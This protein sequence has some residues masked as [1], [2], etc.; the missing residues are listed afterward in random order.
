MRRLGLDVG[1]TDIKL[2]L[3]EDDRIVATDAT[4]TRSEDGGPAAV[5][6][7]LIDLGRSAGAVDSVGVSVPG[8]FDGDGRG[9]L[10]PNL[11]G[12]WAR[13]P[14]R[15][16]ASEGFGSPVALLNDGHAFTLAE[17]RVGA[18][19]GS[20]DVLCVVC[21]TG[22][23]GGLVLGGRL[24][25]GIEDRAGEI[26]HHTVERDGEPC[27]CGNHGCLETIAGARAIARAAGRESFVVKLEVAPEGEPAGVAAL[28]RAGH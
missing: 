18:A 22:V 5:I 15:E 21:G 24:H 1:G 28:S 25:L 20:Q 16:R 17:A 23:G 26:G 4:P 2:A 14:I 9:V 3:L 6:S 12:D 10:F 11:Y 27:G 13:F 7:R 19:R 8:L